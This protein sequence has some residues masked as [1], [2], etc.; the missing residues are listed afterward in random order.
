MLSSTARRNR[1]IGEIVNLM[2][3]DVQRFQ[4]ITTIV[5]LF[6]S[7]PLQVLLAIYFLWRLLGFSIMLGLMFL[8]LLIPLNS[9]VSVK[10]RK[11]QVRFFSKHLIF[12]C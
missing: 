12:V 10:M 6:W 8:I 1:T 7:M 11:Y 4:D 3:A 9:W 5:M 2:S